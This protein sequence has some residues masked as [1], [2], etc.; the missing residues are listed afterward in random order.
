MYRYIAD[1][2]ACNVQSMYMIGLQQLMCRCLRL[3]QPPAPASAAMG[4]AL[5]AS[6]LRLLQPQVVAPQ[7]VAP[8]GGPRSA[9]Q[10][11]AAEEACRVEGWLGWLSTAPRAAA[12]WAV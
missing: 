11:S 5:R 12:L 1:L 6:L 2:A 7:V 9:L 3:P 10:V 4:A 8:T